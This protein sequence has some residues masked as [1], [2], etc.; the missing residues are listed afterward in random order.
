[1]PAACRYTGG[2]QAGDESAHAPGPTSA[3]GY[4]FVFPYKSGPFAMLKM[5][6]LMEEIFTELALCFTTILL[7]F[8]RKMKMLPLVESHKVN[9][10]HKRCPTLFSSW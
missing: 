8:T 7:L 5:E 1:M 4:F 10:E 3:G 6:L 2:F 9:N